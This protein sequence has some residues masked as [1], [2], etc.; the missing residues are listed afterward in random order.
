[1]RSRVTSGGSETGVAAP[2]TLLGLR[3]DALEVACAQGV[4]QVLELQRAGRKPVAARDFYNALR[5]APGARAVF[6]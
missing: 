4:L 3:D 1:L 5:L 2:G 6:T